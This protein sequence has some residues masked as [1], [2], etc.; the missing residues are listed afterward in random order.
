MAKKSE[1]LFGDPLDLNSIRGIYKY[2]LISRRRIPATICPSWK[3]VQVN[4]KFYWLFM[5]SSKCLIYIRIMCEKRYFNLAQCFLYSL[6]NMRQLQT[7]FNKTKTWHRI[8]CWFSW[9]SLF[10]PVLAWC[11]H[12][13]VLFWS[14]EQFYEQTTQELVK[15]GKFS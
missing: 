1:F 5:T 11:D 7:L 14:A 13:I 10:L 12:K 4:D 6:I 9:I 8:V 15:T 3:F 2:H